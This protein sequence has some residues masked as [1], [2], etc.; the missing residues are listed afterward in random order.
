[1]FRRWSLIS[2][3][4]LAVACAPRGSRTPGDLNVASVRRSVSA[5]RGLA[6][7]APTPIEVVDERTF[8]RLLE[9]R[10]GDGPD[11]REGKPSA[12]GDATQIVAAQERAIE[13]ED[14]LGF[15]DIPGRAIFLRAPSERD[16]DRLPLSWILVHELTHALQHQNFSIQDVTQMSNVDEQ[17][18]Y[19]ALVEGDAMV[20]MLAHGAQE[21]FVPISRALQLTMR[22]IRRGEADRLAQFGA[23]P[24]KFEAASPLVRERM[25]FPYSAGTLFVAAVHRT[26]GFTL[27]N[28]MYRRPP[29]T[30]EQVIH[31][32]K[33]LAGE[34]PVEVD[35]PEPPAEYRVAARG[36]MGELGV[37]ALLK[38]CV[39]PDSARSA[40]AGW[41]G[42][43]FTLAVDR[44]NRT[45][46]LW[47]TAWDTREDAAEFAQA[48]RQCSD[49]RAPGQVFQDGYRVSIV[50]GHGVSDAMPI[51]R[52]IVGLR[53]WRAP[54]APPLSVAALIPLPALPEVA[55]ATLS[56][57]RYDSPRLDLA[58]P[59]PPGFK[60]SLADGALV[61]ESDAGLMEVD[62]NPAQ[63]TTEST[64]KVY[65]DFIDSLGLP[66]SS[67]RVITNDRIETP[68]GAG[69][70]RTWMAPGT[71]L[72]LQVVVLPVCNGNGSVLF[73]RLWTDEHP[74]RL[75]EWVVQSARRIRGSAPP[76]CAEL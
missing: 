46:I 17:L 75:L 32:E 18:A 8:V 62:F 30:T 49:T 42:D 55:P 12:L 71:P 31:P 34:G 2:L 44:G 14:T 67:L 43:A 41:G 35:A 73:K 52:Y 11:S 74:G 66:G 1:V 61:L 23:P 28:Q 69:L 13:L 45:L 5:L 48:I 15:Y 10:N 54:F 38:R 39:S 19:L 58:L 59:V 37:I 29:R 21:N 60:A 33:Y 51:H 24:E 64:A 72:K 4:V 7:R 65:R 25:V 9:D 22:N 50:G 27:V 47:G 63:V 6:E 26:G 3:T 20:T 57:D 70:E 16:R 76:V 68:I 40:G 36:R 53:A 56:A